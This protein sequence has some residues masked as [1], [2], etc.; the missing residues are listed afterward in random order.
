MP[1]IAP[2]TGSLR[3]PSD[4][5][6]SHRA[7]MFASM[8]QGCSHLK[9]V[10][11]S[12]DVRST[13][14]AMQ[15]LGARMSI[16]R[17]ASGLDVVVDGWGGEGPR[18][19]AGPIDCGNSGTTTRLICGL[20]GGYPV[21]ATLQGDPSLSKR[22]MGRVIDPLSQMGVRFENADVRG[23][24]DTPRTLP[25]RIVGSARL[26]AGSFT[27]PV[28]S[29][30]VKTAIILAGLNAPGTTTVIEP[31]R[32]RD[33]TELMLPAFGGAIAVENDPRRLHVTGVQTLR[34]TDLEVPADPSSAIF[35]AVACAMTPGSEVTLREVSLNPTRIAAFHVMQRM[36][37][38]VAI[39]ASGSIG[40]EPVGSIQ[41]RYRAGLRAA[42]VPAAEVPALIDEIPILA[43]LATCA[44]GTTVFHEVG[45]LRVKE[46]DRLDAVLEG[47]A[48]LGCKASASGDDLAISGALPER[49]ATLDSRGDHR[50]AMTWALALRCFGLDGRV[51]GMDCIAVS[52]PEFIEQMDMLQS[53]G[54]VRF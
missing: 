38:D 31:A 12:Q 25:L 30:Q 45:E 51:D 47:L 10:L 46:S 35:A 24:S 18:Q 41:V 5:S 43:L 4:K 21:E 39:A 8:A 22:P 7:L 42:S 33:H 48:Q 20:L 3:V 26:A 37:C 1:A 16:V 27:L 9:S 34:A 28:A 36:G 23:V 14:A 53:D 15:A 50:L 6:I 44:T 19:P 2:F 11:D 29:A 52:Y 54:K 17:G 49:A 40:T 13:C 32:S